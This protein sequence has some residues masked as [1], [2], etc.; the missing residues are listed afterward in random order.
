MPLPA[1]LS[2]SPIAA[3]NA[4]T[5]SVTGRGEAS[6]PSAVFR[7][8]AARFRQAS[9]HQRRGGA[10]ADAMH[11]PTSRSVAKHPG[12]QPPGLAWRLWHTPG[13]PSAALRGAPSWWSGWR[14][15]PC[16][17]FEAA[18]RLLATM[19]GTAHPIRAANPT[20][21]KQ[22]F[23]ATDVALGCIGSEVQV[24]YRP[25][26]K[27]TPG[28][29][30]GPKARG[31]GHGA[32]KEA[33]GT[34]TSG[35]GCRRR[36]QCWPGALPDCPASAPG[37][38]ILD[39]IVPDRQRC[40]ETP[41]SIRPFGLARRSAH[42]RFGSGLRLQEGRAPVTHGATDSFGS[43]A[44]GLQAHTHRAWA[45]SR[46]PILLPGVVSGNRLLRTQRT[47]EVSAVL[48]GVS[49]CRALCRD[50]DSPAGN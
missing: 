50:P 42:R 16:L 12:R 4:S 6:A 38:A 44:R 21:G 29:T 30:G 1:G 47:L 49:R 31:A 36:G 32:A 25:H 40:R 26:R 48:V 11:R 18:R 20:L 43:R 7:L 15:P 28:G 46:G 2:L 24:L 35:A 39:R 45:A 5:E 8:R 13:W 27:R 19:H 33:G 3:T 22:R 9:E 41:G 23:R 37:E 14:C 10:P 34:V 17:G